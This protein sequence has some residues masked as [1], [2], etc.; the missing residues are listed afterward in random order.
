MNKQFDHDSFP[1]WEKQYKLEQEQK[2]KL[3]KEK[4][5]ILLKESLSESYPDITWAQLQKQNDHTQ[6]DDG[7][8]HYK[9]TAS[10]QIYSWNF[11]ENKWMQHGEDYQDSLGDMFD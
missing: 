8:T 11:I 1:S 7:C 3:L 6:T 5:L 10:G 4:Q 2:Q 9:D